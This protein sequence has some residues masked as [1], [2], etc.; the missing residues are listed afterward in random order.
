MARIQVTKSLCHSRA[1][2]KTA[3]RLEDTS[4]LVAP[5]LPAMMG[6][7]LPGGL[8]SAQDNFVNRSSLISAFSYAMIIYHPLSP[9]LV[10]SQRQIILDLRLQLRSLTSSTFTTWNALPPGQFGIEVRFSACNPNNQVLT[11]T[12]VTTNSYMK[13]MQRRKSRECPIRLM[14]YSLIQIDIFLQGE[15]GRP[16]GFSSDPNSKKIP[17][18]TCNSC[19]LAN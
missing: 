4:A 1:I 17:I 7:S 13:I 2:L 6:S 18:Y 3:P 15:R 5:M 10:T 19:K 9:P 11:I 16:W 12:V 14:P 8:N